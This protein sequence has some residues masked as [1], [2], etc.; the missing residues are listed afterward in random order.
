MSSI[1][2]LWQKF[3]NTDRVADLPRQPRRKVTTVYQDAQ[4]IANHIENCYMTAAD[5]A[6]ATIGTHGR[7]VC[8]KTVV[9]R[10]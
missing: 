9:R 2:R 1:V 5:T 10:L 4:I 6:R 7:P 8:F 3:Q